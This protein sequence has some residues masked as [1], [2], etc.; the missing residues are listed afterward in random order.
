LNLGK[1]NVEYAL[2]K[3]TQLQTGLLKK[4]KFSRLEQ[5]NL[6]EKYMRYL[7]YKVTE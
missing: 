5:G 4:I 2:S 7:P 6:K 3:N 1:Y